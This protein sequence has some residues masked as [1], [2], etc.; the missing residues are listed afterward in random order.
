[1]TE[2]AQ[3]RALNP[4]GVLSSA[5]AFWW[6][7]QRIKDAAD[8]YDPRVISRIRPGEA[9][10]A[11]DYIELLH[12]RAR[13]VGEI[14]AAAAGYDAM[15]MPTTADTAPTIAEAIKD[16]DS[17]FRFN[18]RMLRNTSIVNLFDGCALSVP[19]HESRQRTGRHDDRRHA[20]HR[21][22]DSGY[23][24][25]RG[26][27]RCCRDWMIVITLLLSPTP[28]QCRPRAACG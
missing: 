10:T 12:Q 4:R 23:R 17:Y 5:E 26:G 18:S 27:G 14:N 3:A 1:M 6:H 13:F 20:K 8:K 25:R 28:F 24:P 11:A 19:C 15:L 22:Q 2:F 16:D 7:R 21:P 9:I